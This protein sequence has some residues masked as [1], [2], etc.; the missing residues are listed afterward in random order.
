MAWVTTVE[1]TNHSGSPHCCA[2]RAA[3]W[4]DWKWFPNPSLAGSASSV[5]LS[6]VGCAA[7][8]AAAAA[9]HHPSA[10]NQEKRISVDASVSHQ[11][12]GKKA[13]PSLWD[14]ARLER[15]AIE[16]AAHCIVCLT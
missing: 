15:P 12:Q 1:S 4:I 9:A 6:H 7:A 14:G 8:A 3:S 11:L 13:P 10:Q 16:L 5:T 2:L